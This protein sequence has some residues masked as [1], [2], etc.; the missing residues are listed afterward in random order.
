MYDK[1]KLL[2]RI[3]I[4]SGKCGEPRNLGCQSFDW[5]TGEI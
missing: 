4:F 3:V 1:L 2:P 5:L